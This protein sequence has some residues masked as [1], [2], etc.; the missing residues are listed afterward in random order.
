VRESIGDLFVDRA[1]VLAVGHY[2]AVVGAAKN[3][4]AIALGKAEIMVRGDD[5][6]GSVRELVLSNNLQPLRYDQLDEAFAVGSMKV[7]PKANRV[8]RTDDRLWYVFQVRNPA[9]AEAGALKIKVAVIIRGTG[10][11]NAGFVRRTAEKEVMANQLTDDGKMYWVG[12]SIP[13]SSFAPG[14]Y[15]ILIMVTDAIANE[16]YE[17][18][19]SFSVTGS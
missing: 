11:S 19:D 7:I 8:F 1:V 15:E 9:R 17:M 12:N 3:G 4:T 14:K 18:K 13:L 2:S 6:K 16:K 5:G 10:D